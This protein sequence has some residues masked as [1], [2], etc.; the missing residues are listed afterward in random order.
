MSQ[1]QKKFQKN[2]KNAEYKIL[3][4]IAWYLDLTVKTMISF[5]VAL[6][7]IWIFFPNSSFILKLIALILISPFISFAL[8]K[9]KIGVFLINFL[10]QKIEFYM[11]KWQK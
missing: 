10:Y 9:L 6:V 8:S 2:Q 1:K 7:I 5:I 3:S 11:K 4:Y